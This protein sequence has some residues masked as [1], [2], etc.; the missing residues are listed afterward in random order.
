M[1]LIRFGAERIYI[2]IP[3]RTEAQQ[4]ASRPFNNQELNMKSSKLQSILLCVSA[5]V[6]TGCYRL[7]PGLDGEYDYDAGVGGGQDMITVDMPFARGYRSLCTQCA[8]GSY[9]H[10][11]TSTYYDLDLDTPNNTDDLVY[12][13]AGGVGYVHDDPASGF[14]VH[15]NIDLGDGTYIV[16][17]HLSEALIEDGEEVAAGMMVGYEGS[18]GDSSGDHV[19]FGRHLGSAS[20]DAAFGESVEGLSVW[21]YDLAT[22]ELNAFKTEQMTCSLSSGHSYESQLPVSLWHPNGTLV[23]T[24]DASTVYLIE[25]GMARP[26]VSESVFW[27]M[28]YDF[29][30]LALVSPEE[31]ACYGAGDSVDGTYLVK[32]VYDG[33]KVWL[34]V[35]DAASATRREVPAAYWQAVLKSWGIQA[36]TY[37]DLM[38]EEQF[39]TS[40]EMI[41]YDSE[42]AVFRDGTLVRENSSATVYAVSDG[43]AMPIEDWDTFLVMDFGAREILWV[44]DDAVAAVQGRVGSCSVDAHCVSFEDITTCGG[45]SGAEETFPGDDEEADGEEAAEDDPDGEDSPDTTDTGAGSETDDTGDTGTTSPAEATLEAEWSR[46][47]DLFDRIELSGEFVHADGVNEGWQTLA[48]VYNAT[49]VVY[50]RHDVG[51][52]D[53]LRFSV[54]F[55]SGGSTSW[56]CLAPFPPGTLQGIADATYGG[57]PVVVNPEADPVSAGCGLLLQVP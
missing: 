33:V 14:G 16:L 2:L 5:F 48:T 42:P 35:E 30:D 18:T 38:T 4:I 17:G 10:F 46:A 12:A 43:I 37:D 20:E 41:S 56:S 52:G 34:V 45:P 23:K 11:Y 57:T 32:A 29:A 24:P 53:S 25:E 3:I 55:E 39:G 31:L 28:H 51:P 54:E 19:H 36:S 13:P 50:E 26:I 1:A 27:D 49:E 6:L 22:G 15:V 7:P 44:D 9:S 8:G 47:G 21:A 40:L